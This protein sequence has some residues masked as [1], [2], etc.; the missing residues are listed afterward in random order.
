MSH[1]V[2]TEQNRISFV[3]DK[4]QSFACHIQ[5]ARTTDWKATVSNTTRLAP[6]VLSVLTGLLPDGVVLPPLPVWD[7]DNPVIAAKCF[8]RWQAEAKRVAFEP[9]HD[10]E[11]AKVA[12]HLPGTVC[13]PLVF[14]SL[15][16]H[17]EE[18]PA[19]I[20]RLPRDGARKEAAGVQSRT[21]QNGCQ[22]ISKALQQL[23]S[24]HKSILSPGQ[25]WYRS[26][27]AQNSTKAP[28]TV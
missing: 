23:S 13:E 21:R 9:L 11:R 12:Q 3:F 6:L 19:T 24:C 10:R 8:H 2:R 25:G 5:R 4:A 26:A 18:S 7:G 27:K 1:A 20:R 28:L 15:G 17:T 16:G 22:Q 14:S